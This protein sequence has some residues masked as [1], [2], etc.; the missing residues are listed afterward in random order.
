MSAVFADENRA[1]LA[2]N[3]TCKE[4]DRFT[5][6][7]P[8]SSRHLSAQFTDW[9]QAIPASADREETVG[10]DVQAAQEALRERGDRIPYSDLRK[11]LG[12]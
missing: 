2:W 12:L 10:D 8:I 1:T 7:E 11:E 3:A 4:S 5:S 6:L 9:S